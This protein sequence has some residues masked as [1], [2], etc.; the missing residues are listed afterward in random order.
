MR[1]CLYFSGGNIQSKKKRRKRNPFDQVS[2]HLLI[3]TLCL[4]RR[5][6]PMSNDPWAV[7]VVTCMCSYVRCQNAQHTPPI[8]S[9]SAHRHRYSPCQKQSSLCTTRHNTIPVMSLQPRHDSRLSKRLREPTIYTI[10]PQV[11]QVVNW[12]RS[13][14]VE[15]G[16]CI[17]D[18]HFIC[19]MI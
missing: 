10:C 5:Y 2:L 17:L 7:T 1:N 6:S 14:C 9:C 16:T 15:G 12:L 18:L 8:H 11:V 4:H 13:Y 19:A 3:L